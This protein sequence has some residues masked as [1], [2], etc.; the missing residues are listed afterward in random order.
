QVPAARHHCC[1]NTASAVHLHNTVPSDV[2]QRSHSASHLALVARRRSGVFSRRGD[3]EVC[4]P[5]IGLAA[6]GHH[7]GGSWYIERYVS[8]ASA[9]RSVASSFFFSVSTFGY[10]RSSCSTASTI[11]AATTSRVNHLLSAG[12]T[13]QGAWFDAVARIVSSNAC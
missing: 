11:E 8:L 9:A 12:T 4:H 1:R 2:R 5:F 7:D 3:R 13:N 10:V 6:K